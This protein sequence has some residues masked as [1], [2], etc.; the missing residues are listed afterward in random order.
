LAPDPVPGV[1]EPVR[2]EVD[3]PA[4]VDAA[5]D[6][7]SGS[8]ARGHGTAGEGAESAVGDE[9]GGEAGAGVEGDQ[10]VRARAVCTEDTPEPDELPGVVAVVGSAAGGGEIRLDHVP[11]PGADPGDRAGQPL[12]ARGHG[13]DPVD[14]RSVAL[15][16][17]GAERADRQGQGRAGRVEQASCLVLRLVQLVVGAEG[18]AGR[19]RRQGVV[20]GADDE[21]HVGAAH[22]I[23]QGCGERCGP[24]G[25]V[26]PSVVTEAEVDHPGSSLAGQLECSHEVVLPEPGVREL[27]VVVED[28]DA[29]QPTRRPHRSQ[30]GEQRFQR[31]VEGEAG[32]VRAVAVRV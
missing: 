22:E 29:D 12:P 9:R 10:T 26:G 23:V 5:Q 3:G 16:V 24:V 28:A 31:P 19:E 18:V 15:M 8:R 2:C 17:V 32:H 20:A 1:G 13:V 25:S 14:S 6:E 7:G 30:L 21:N 27:G 11:R 4:G